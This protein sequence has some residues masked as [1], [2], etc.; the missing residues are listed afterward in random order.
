[1]SCALAQSIAP[2]HKA[3]MTNAHPPIEFIPVRMFAKY[4]AHVIP[5]KPLITFEFVEENRNPDIV[6]FGDVLEDIKKR[7]SH[8]I[9]ERNRLVTE[10]ARLEARVQSLE[11]QLLA[12]E[13]AQSKAASP[14]PTMTP[15]PPIPNRN[16]VAGERIRALVEEI[17]ACIA[18]MPRSRDMVNTEVATA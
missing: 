7:T 8:L 17:D 14:A 6:L 10:N 15:P 11:N 9:A 5:W 16:P 1:M 2:P 3:K 4:R 12:C 13:E 18:L